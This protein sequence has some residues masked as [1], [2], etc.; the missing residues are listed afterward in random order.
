MLVR[1]TERILSRSLSVASTTELPGMRVKPFGR[2]TLV[3]MRFGAPKDGIARLNLK[4]LKFTPRF[5]V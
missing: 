3:G 4:A 1:L 2:E 5:T